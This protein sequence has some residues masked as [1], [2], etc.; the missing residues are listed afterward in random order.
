MKKIIETIKNDNINE[1][2]ILFNNIESV[3]LIK[4]LIFCIHINNFKYF[5]LLF[6]KFKL[7]KNYIE[8]IKASI[9]NEYKNTQFIEKILNNKIILN[10]ILKNKINL[11]TLIEIDSVEILEFL[12]TSSIINFDKKNIKSSFEYSI[13]KKQIEIFKYLLNNYPD[14]FYI[15]DRSFYRKM[16][17]INLE[18]LKIYIENDNFLITPFNVELTMSAYNNHN[19]N[20]FE[21]FLEKKYINPV[22]INLIFNERFPVMKYID[23][24]LNN[25]YAIQ[26]IPK[27]FKLKFKNDNLQK[28]IE[29]AKIKYNAINF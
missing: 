28:K 22:L 12:L 25:R 8:L 23:A 17:K 26:L 27:N 7:E 2:N 10:T 18:Y 6:N 24:L 15:P 1:F 29:L 13:M 14:I 19:F 20:N 21:Y 4:S 16:A 11:L 5:S 9:N 3:T